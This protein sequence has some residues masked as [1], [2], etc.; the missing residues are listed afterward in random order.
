MKRWHLQLGAVV[1]A[2]MLSA[3]VLAPWLA[4][5]WGGG[6]GTPS[7]P[8]KGVS[9]AQPARQ[10]SSSAA[11]QSTPR[12]GATL[13]GHSTRP[14]SS[15]APGNWPMFRGNQAQTGLAEGSLG[16][17]LVLGWT[18]TTGEAVRSSPVIQDGRVY[19]GSGDG[20]LYCLRLGDGG[21][22]WEFDAGEAIDGPP[23]VVDGKVLFGTNSG[24]FFALDAA[25]GAKLWQ[26]KTGEKIV[27]SANYFRR[28]GQLCV[29]VG[30]W[31]F[32]LYCLAGQGGRQLWS[33]STGNYINGSP[34]I[35]EGQI[36][37]GGCDNLLHVIGAAGGGQQAAIDVG[38]YI[39][40]SAAI[41]GQ[42]VYVGNYKGFYAID[43]KAQ[44]IAWSY[45][46]GG[47]AFFSSPALSGD[48][49]VVGSRDN[50]LHCLARSDGHKFWSFQ[51]QGKVESSPVVCDGKVVFGS[52]DGRVYMVSLEDGKEL[53]RYEVGDL[54]DSSPAVAGGWVVIGAD[55]GK[56]YAFGPAQNR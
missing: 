17:D 2:A 30:S 47:E 51:T 56:V 8:G 48:R 22:E 9:A 12:A 26:F 54:I 23:L 7:G 28:D 15:P 1:L 37:V 45:E 52:E 33:V 46:G 4:G 21:K 16:K 41:D 39:G 38:A 44:R 14:A 10:N 19:V 24:D 3:A 49:L 40:G 29:V 6:K 35:D 5:R 55:D 20:K 11:T 36:C 43:L 34:A 53:W 25:K 18:F 32:K 31:D 13:A 50:A 42:M 27:G